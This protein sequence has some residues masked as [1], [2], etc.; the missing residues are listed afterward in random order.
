MSTY[1][2]SDIELQIPMVIF[3]EAGFFY[4]HGNYTKNDNH[5]KR[6]SN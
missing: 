6:Y 1:G 2:C 4:H 5:M 3:K